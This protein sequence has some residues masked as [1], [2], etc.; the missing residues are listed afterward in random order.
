MNNSFNN[1]LRFKADKIEVEKVI[2]VLCF[3]IFNEVNKIG[4][5]YF[6]RNHMT[7]EEYDNGEFHKCSN[8][9]ILK[10]VSSTVKIYSYVT[11]YSMNN[12]G[13]FYYLTINDKPVYLLAYKASEEGDSFQIQ[14]QELFEDYEKEELNPYESLMLNIFIRDYVEYCNNNGDTVSL[15][16]IFA[17]YIGDDKDEY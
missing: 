15:N 14:N 6:I 3:V 1:I 2:R 12:K 5:D 4:Q 13:Y 7:D 10:L 17:G 9:Y 8:P 16:D 11:E